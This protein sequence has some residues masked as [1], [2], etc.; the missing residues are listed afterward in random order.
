MAT[1]NSSK[2]ELE[3][4]SD[5]E[6]VN[7]VLYRVI[8]AASR[9]LLI[10]RGAEPKNTYEVFDAFIEK[11][12]HSKLISEVYKEIVETARDDSHSDFS[13]KKSTI[14]E[15]ADAVTGLYERMDDSLQF[16]NEPVREEKE[17]DAVSK[18][19]RKKDF[20]GVACPL[21]FVKTKIELATLKTGDIL[22]ILLDDGEPVENVPASVKNEGHIILE[23][24]KSDNHW[25]VVIQKN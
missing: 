20:R 14:L 19:T 6:A 1:I 8:F 2:K 25:I 12:I 4:I 16:G 22:E 7:M 21:N 23:Q 11:F 5:P 3:N 13:D 24:N 15:F 18:V 10:T 17:K 9:M